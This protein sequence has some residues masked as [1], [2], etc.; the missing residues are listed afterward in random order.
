MIYRHQLLRHN[1]WMYAG[2]LFVVIVNAAESR[3]A[4]AGSAGDETNI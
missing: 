2:L 3:T 4:V 1:V